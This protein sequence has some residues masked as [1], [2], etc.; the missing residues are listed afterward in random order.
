MYHGAPHIFKGTSVKKLQ[1]SNK[2][3]ILYD[4]KAALAGQG[5]IG[6][7]LFPDDFCSDKN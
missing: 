6:I 3:L 7:T 5:G 1:S 2:I 4:H